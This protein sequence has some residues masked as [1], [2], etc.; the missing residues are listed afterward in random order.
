[1]AGNGKR[2]TMLRGKGKRVM[3]KRETTTRGKGKDQKEKGYSGKVN[4]GNAKRYITAV[5]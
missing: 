4:T 5:K 1:M 2:K 3:N